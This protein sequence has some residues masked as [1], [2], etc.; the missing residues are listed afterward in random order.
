M[1]MM[2]MMTMRV[3]NQIIVAHFFFLLYIH[4]HGRGTLSVKP[5]LLKLLKP[6]LLALLL[7]R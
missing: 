1:M 3:Y 5:T 6:I 2:M 7:N 4:L